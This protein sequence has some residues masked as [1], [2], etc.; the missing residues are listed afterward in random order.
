MGDRF[1][2]QQGL[3][4]TDVRE[5]DYKLRQKEAKKKVRE[6]NPKF[7]SDQQLL[8]FAEELK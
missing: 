2:E 8:Q 4:I 6:Q 7:Y 1:Y 3:T 5:R